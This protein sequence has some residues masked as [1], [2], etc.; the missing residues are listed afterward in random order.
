MNSDAETTSIRDGGLQV[1][2]HD[3][4]VIGACGDGLRKFHKHFPD[5]SVVITEELCVKHACDFDWHWAAGELLSEEFRNVWLQFH[6]T[7]RHALLQTEEFFNTQDQIFDRVSEGLQGSAPTAN[8][9]AYGVLMNSMNAM[10]IDV[11]KAMGDAINVCCARFFAQLARKQS[12]IRVRATA[13]EITIN[14]PARTNK[15]A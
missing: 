10:T 3:L 9:H 11:A 14:F 1:T 12:E 7:L 2:Y 15:S 6:D 5:T 4:D 8:T 13:T